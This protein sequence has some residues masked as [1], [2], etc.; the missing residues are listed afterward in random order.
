MDVL[1]S[2]TNNQQFPWM[3]LYKQVSLLDSISCHKLTDPDSTQSL[4]PSPRASHSLNFVSDC[5]VLFGGGCEGGQSLS[6]S[7]LVSLIKCVKSKYFRPASLL[8]LLVMAFELCNLNVCI[9]AFKLVVAFHCS[10]LFVGFLFCCYISTRA[11]IAAESM[12][13]SIYQLNSLN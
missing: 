11:I 3:R 7:A 6:L 12:K 5:L 2:S 8:I 9:E 4:L 13:L 10:C 1:K